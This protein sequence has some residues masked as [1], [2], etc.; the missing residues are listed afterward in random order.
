M[1]I[2]RRRRLF[3]EDPHLLRARFQPQ[4]EELRRRVMEARNKLSSVEVPDELMEL[5]ARICVE[6]G[7]CGHRADIATFQA[8]RAMAAL[9]GKGRVE[10][11]HVREAAE[12]ALLHRLRRTPF[13][14]QLKELERLDRLIRRGGKS[15]ELPLQDVPLPEE[16][17]S[18][19]PGRATVPMREPGSRRLKSPPR[20][21]PRTWRSPLSRPWSRAR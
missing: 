1:E 17:S 4:Q 16:D 7:V 10:E 12:M 19:V 18:P 9:E 21:Y 15:L 2:M 3:L 11:G 13:D 20:P 14:D 5:I 6:L 8:A